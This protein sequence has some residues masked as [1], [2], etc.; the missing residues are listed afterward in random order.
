MTNFIPAIPDASRDP[1]PD[2]ER[3]PLRPSWLFPLLSSGVILTHVVFFA[4]QIY[5]PDPQYAD[6]GGINAELLPEGDSVDAGEAAPEGDSLQGAATEPEEAEETAETAEPVPPPPVM[7]PDAEPTP[8]KKQPVAKARKI[9]KQPPR[10]QASGSAD[11]SR[12][13]N[14]KQRYGLPGGSG[15]GSGTARVAGRYGVP[16]GR[17]TAGAASQASCL[18][19][20]AASVRGHLPATTSLG[21][22]R[23]YVTFYVNQG[24]GISGISASASSP[25]HAALARRIIASSH[26]PGS[27]GGSFASQSLTFE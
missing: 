25:A 23:A 10:K 6:L 15:K 14:P 21:P 24:G 2:R 1:D 27:C 17:G 18:A 20:V 26:G 12:G 11:K 3:P 16:G 9:D 7:E 22:G 4:S 8:I 13:A 5:W 19:Q